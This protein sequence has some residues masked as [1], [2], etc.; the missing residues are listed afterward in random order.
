MRIKV[1]Q[2]D[3]EAALVEGRTS[4]QRKNIWSL[5]IRDMIFN[6]KQCKVLVLRDMSHIQENLRLS[7]MNKMMSLV[8][9]SISHEMLTP[10][11]CIIQTVRTFKNRFKDK[12]YED[13]R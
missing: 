9:S 11:C 1:T 12:R 5:Y 13:D 10:I 8:Q 2:H 3:D 6:N 7:T 4:R